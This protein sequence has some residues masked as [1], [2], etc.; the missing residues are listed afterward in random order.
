MPHFSKVLNVKQGF[1]FDKDKQEKVGFL[2]SLKIGDTVLPADMMTIMNPLNPTEKLTDG[3][4]AVLSS[5]DWN[6]GSTD[7]MYFSGQVSTNNRQLIAEMLL[8][9]WSN[10]MVEFKFSI[11]EYEPSQKKFFKS[12]FVDDVLLGLLEKNGADLNL[13]VAD[14]PS[15]EVQSP[16]N[17]SFR[18]GIKPKSQEQQVQLAVGDQRKV[19]KTW[20]ITEQ[21]A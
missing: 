11:Y 10:V 14:D 2:L 5:F 4:M 7:A 9:T 3:V 8:G 15:H 17:Y 16:Q 18:I 19:T 1:N 20:G 13:D 6:T 21:A 12:A